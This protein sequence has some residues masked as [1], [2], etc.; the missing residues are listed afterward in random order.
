MHAML[1]GVMIDRRCGAVSSLVGGRA[2]ASDILRGGSIRSAMR[3][4][5]A[6]MPP[7][8][9]ERTAAKRLGS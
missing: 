8:D 7:M 5:S 9:A 6:R 4:R 2:C 3:C 1:A